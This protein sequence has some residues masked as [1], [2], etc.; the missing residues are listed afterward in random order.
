MQQLRPQSGRLLLAAG[1]KHGFFGRV[2][3]TSKGPYASLNCSFAVGDEP[4][5]VTQNLA[6][7][8][9]YLD[10]Q[11]ERLV[12]ASQV[13]G[14][15]VLDVDDAPSLLEVRATEADA[16]LGMRTNCALCVRTADCVPILVGCCVSGAATAI[17]AGWRGV[18]AGV[19]TRAIHRLFEKGARPESLVAAIGPHIGLAAFEVSREVAMQLDAVAPLARAVDWKMGDR[20]HVRLAGLVLAQLQAVGV[21]SEQV[22][23]IDGCTF[24][25]QTDFFSFRRDG[26]FSGRQVSAICPLVR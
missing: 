1:F 24:E 26:R 22:D 25:N 9:G 10:V 15:N 23:E 5:D 14:S 21:K 18:I 17:H 8:A 13:H 19:V 4:S 7:V 16:L 11:T 20:P 3:G 2:G 6:R 12:A